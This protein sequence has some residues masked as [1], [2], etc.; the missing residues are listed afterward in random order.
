MNAPNSSTEPTLIH[1]LA[2]LYEVYPERPLFTFLNEQG[3]ITDTLTLGQLYAEAT[4]LGAY[5]L[6]KCQIQPGQAVLLVYM[7]SL[8]FVKA[9]TACLL[10]GIIP[11][12]VAA[13]T[14]F[15]GNDV[16]EALA[17]IAASSKSVAALTHNEFLQ[18]VRFDAGQ[19]QIDD[20]RYPALRWHN[21]RIENKALTRLPEWTP[22]PTDLA[23]LQYT[24]GSTATPKGVMI[25]HGNLMH[26][27]AASTEIAGLSPET[28]TAMWLP[29]YHDFCLILGISAALYGN[30]QLYLMSPYAFLFNPA[31]WMD[32]ITN[33]QATC[34][35]A[36]DFG[37]HYVV[38]RTTPEQRAQWDLSSLQIALCSAE[39]IQLST[40][41]EFT[42]AFAPA[43]FA[44]E[45]FC[46]GYGLAEHTGGA[47]IFG[48]SFLHLDRAAL[49]QR[50]V[51]PQATATAGSVAIVSSG[52]SIAGLDVRIVHSEA[53]HECGA[54]EVGEIWLDSP[55]KALGYYGMP[56]L[57]ETVF[58]ASL[59]S[60]ERR[61][62]RTGDLGFVYR[63]ELFVVGRLKDL[64]IFR[65]RN[66][67]PQDIE[68]KIEQA[69]PALRAGC[70]VAFQFPDSTA[71]GV[72]AEAK[73]LTLPADTA[74]AVL[75]AIRDV[76]QQ[77]F[78]LPG[79][80]ALVAPNTVLKTTSGK[81][82][83]QETMLA[84]QRG[85]FAPNLLAEQ[86]ETVA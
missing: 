4:A 33:V 68:T 18:L 25:S 19:Q 51:E 10:T 61:Y 40:I 79:S 39:P 58:N 6:E 70:A 44:P 85:V 17:A 36:P 23:F 7:P 12:P 72:I 55:S 30:G 82:R 63:D 15:T 47:T 21:T 74:A 35:A 75:N 59:P 76:L 50:R 29:H 20:P 66:I 8:D 5:L 26:Q 24:S 69:H 54:G 77:E 3:R 73:S 38:K 13:P 67:Y 28:R 60:S 27:L 49:E 34:T 71:I 32:V 78:R 37:Y 14:P 83:R 57:S 56:E 9:F 1:R 80:I 43:H 46:P 2:A 52:R 11:V 86:P 45:A 84:Y 62:L 65:G 81:R 48:R 53:G 31:V 22:A 41:Q 64:L 42:Q 16:I